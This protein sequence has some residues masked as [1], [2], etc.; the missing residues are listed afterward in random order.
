MRGL[1]SGTVEE[2]LARAANHPERRIIIGT[3]EDVNQPIICLV[4]KCQS[5]NTTNTMLRALCVTPLINDLCRV[6][7]ARGSKGSVGGYATRRGVALDLS[8]LLDDT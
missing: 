5:Y 1:L 2:I 7:G 4:R 8:M 3:P 6:A